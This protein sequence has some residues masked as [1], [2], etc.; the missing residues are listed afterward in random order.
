MLGI[1]VASGKVGCVLVAD[2]ELEHTQLSSKAAHSP[3]VAVEFLEDWIRDLQPNFIV[4]EEAYR[5]SRKAAHVRAIIA[6]LADYA[7]T[8]KINNAAIARTQ[9]CA[10]KYEE[11]ALLAIKYPQLEPSVPHKRKLWEAEPRQMIV[12]E[13]LALAE[14]VTA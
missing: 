8:T 13:A 11:A 14:A 2:G 6:A 5:A 12:F 10:N 3:E 9:R 4:T 1:A 7:N